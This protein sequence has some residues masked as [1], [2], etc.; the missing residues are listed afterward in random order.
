MSGRGTVIVLVR[1][2]RPGTAKTRLIPAL[3]THGAAIAQ[4][5]MTLRTLAAVRGSG[6]AAQLHVSG[7]VAA[8]AALY[9]G[10]WVVRPQADGDLGH[11]LATAVAG[12]TGPVAVIGTDCPGLVADHV[13]A[14]F[15]LLRSAGV[16][17]GPAVDGGYYLLAMR[18]FR[19]ELF[20]GIDWSTD[21]VAA[22]TRAAAAAAGL[23]VAELPPLADVDTPG[24]LPLLPPVYSPSRL[25][26]T[27]ATGSIGTRFLAGLLRDLPDLRVT[28]VARFAPSQFRALVDRHAG[29]VTV[30]EQDLRSLRLTPS[31]RKLLAESDGLW[32]LAARTALDDADDAATWA[33]NDGGTA[34][35][36]DLLAASDASGPL[37]HL[38]T[39]FVCGTRIGRVA[40]S[41]LPET[42][43]RNAYEASKAA[44]E[45]RVRSAMAA[46]L[47]GAVL[48]PAVVVGDDADDGSPKAVDAVAAAV[49][50]ADRAG[51][52]LLV[53]GPADAALNVVHADWLLAALS[54]VAAA[55]PDGRTFHL[56]A[57]RPLRLAD[58]ATVVDPATPARE[59]PPVSRRLDRALAPLRPYL[60]AGVDFD[61]ANLDAVAPD[62]VGLSE[63]DPAVVLQHRQRQAAS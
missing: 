55:P 42:G 39:A 9:P 33:T 50:A 35:V 17:I 30:L 43:F 18:R 1:H 28:V 40:E 46:G 41:D 48:R 22:Q 34:A 49:L 47:R 14:A 44:A 3:G 58:I 4:H 21:R 57:R 6:L 8:A 53:R 20:R 59:L 10:P 23:T 13:T 5:R 38:S 52:P 16:S 61:R 63:C 25:A 7:D 2:P 27:G 15:H 54:A 19:P 45:R 56:T 12:V 29:R 51:E 36:L 32:H 62:L 26:V 60:S 31:Q 11:R 24:E 37:L